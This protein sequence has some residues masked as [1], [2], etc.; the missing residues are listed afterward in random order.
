[1]SHGQ[2]TFLIWTAIILLI[3]YLANVNLGHFITGLIQAAQHVHNSNA[4]Q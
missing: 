1:M 4:G 3:C 2:R